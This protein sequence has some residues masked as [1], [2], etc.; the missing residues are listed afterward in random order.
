EGRDVVAH[1]LAEADAHR[2]ALDELPV[3][4]V[5]DT[6]AR[7]AAEDPEPLRHRVVVPARPGAGLRRLDDVDVQAVLA[8]LAC[9]EVAVEEELPRAV[10]LFVRVRALECVV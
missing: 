2:V 1:V 7:A 4:L 8:R 10:A 9:A 5:L 6:D 3:R